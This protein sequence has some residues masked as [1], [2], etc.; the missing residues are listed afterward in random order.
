MGK[1]VQPPEREMVHIFLLNLKNFFTRNRLLAGAFMLL[2]VVCLGGALFGVNYIFCNIDSYNIYMSEQNTYS[3]TARGGER[4]NG[5]VEAAIEEFGQDLFLAF[6]EFSNETRSPVDK[7]DGTA[8]Y[9]GITAIAYYSGEYGAMLAEA[10]GMFTRDQRAGRD[11]IVIL[12][13]GVYDSSYLG[14]KYILNGEEFTVEGFSS[15][16]FVPLFALENSFAESYTLSFGRRLSEEEIES[17]R[18]ASISLNSGGEC[19]LNIPEEDSVSFLDYLPMLVPTFVLVLLGFVNL[20]YLYTYFV[21][22]RERMY[23]VFRLCGAGQGKVLGLFL[24]EAFF[25]FTAAFLAGLLAYKLIMPVLFDASLLSMLQSGLLISDR[26]GFGRWACVY[27]ASAACFALA[28][29]PALVRAARADAVV[30]QEE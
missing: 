1:A 8:R 24:A 27:L 6:T 25:L 9:D 18:Q 10:G 17:L 15:G 7:E 14:Q 21:R 4:T 23:A 22:M 3:V 2:L 28:F 5:V 19:I 26:L 20:N 11:K 16:N 29:V 30:R 13:S 12:D